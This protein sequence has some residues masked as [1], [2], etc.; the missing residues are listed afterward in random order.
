MFYVQLEWKVCDTLAKP[1]IAC[2][3]SALICHS[4]FPHLMSA[5]GLSRLHVQLF[6][7]D[8]SMSVFLTTEVMT[9]HCIGSVIIEIDRLISASALNNPNPWCHCHTHVTLSSV[10]QLFYTAGSGKQNITLSA[11]HVEILFWKNAS[12]KKWLS[13]WTTEWLLLLV[14]GRIWLSRTNETALFRTLHFDPIYEKF[15]ILKVN[16]INLDQQLQFYFEIINNIHP[17][18]F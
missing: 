8:G 14:W 10:V 5:P 18:H 12:N 6:E 16:D 13:V 7:N 4:Y 3:V 11:N 9:V 17:D 15:K 1:Y 2:A